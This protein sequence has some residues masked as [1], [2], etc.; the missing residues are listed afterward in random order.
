[1]F[2][3]AYFKGGNPILKT[4]KIAVAPLVYPV[5]YLIT[6]KDKKGNFYENIYN[7]PQ[8]IK[9]N[10][11]KGKIYVLINGGSFS[12]SSII[13]S[14]LK[15]SKRATFVGQETGGAFNGTVAGFMPMVQLPHSKIKIKVG[16]MTCEP[17]FKSIEGRGIFPDK[18]IIPTIQDRINGKDPEME[19][20]ITQI[21]EVKN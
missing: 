4:I 11:F 9:E 6:K 21:Q 1:L 13:S 16:I 17:H 7:K 12:A 10:A 14:N 20:I 15:G 5:F 8:E 3:Y 19:W 18:E 2:K